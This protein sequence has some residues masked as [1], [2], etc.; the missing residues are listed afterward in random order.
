M[1]ILPTTAAA[2][3]IGVADVFRAEANVEAGAKYMRHLIDTDLDDP[4]L[5]AEERFRLAL[6]SYNAGPN[7]VATLRRRAAAAGLDPNVWYGNVEAM[8]AT[9]GGQETVAYVS[10]IEKYLFAFRAALALED[11]RGPGDAR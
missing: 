4:G 1:Q 8:A 11:L 2:H 9:H 10:N 3:P 6:A 7:R 5:D